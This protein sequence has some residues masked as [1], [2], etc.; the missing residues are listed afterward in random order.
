MLK[1]LEFKTSIGVDCGIK[2]FHSDHLP[3]ANMPDIPSAFC[4]S[5][6]ETKVVS[7]F[8]SELIFSEQGLC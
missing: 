2:Y 7:G 3:L 5:I 8:N 6:S 1:F 4:L